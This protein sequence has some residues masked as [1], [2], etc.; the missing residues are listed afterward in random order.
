MSDTASF[1]TTDGALGQW[2]NRDGVTISA[3]GESRE[4]LVAYAGGCALQ[5]VGLTTLANGG[6][7]LQAWGTS[8]AAPHVAGV[9]ALMQEQAYNPGPFPFISLEEIRSK[10]RSSADQVGVAPL[11]SLSLNYSFDGER[12]GV[13][14]APGALE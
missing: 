11:D 12:E 2:P 8:L 13:V 9:V 5:T 7:L 3:P 14:W 1:F 4:D 6:G 10:L